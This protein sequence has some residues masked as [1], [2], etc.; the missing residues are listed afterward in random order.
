MKEEDKAKEYEEFLGLI[1]KQLEITLEKR[2]KNPVTK[3]AKKYVKL[4][5]N[6]EAYYFYFKILIPIT[7]HFK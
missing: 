3:F 2:P 4:S 1:Y 5:L 7:A 6:I